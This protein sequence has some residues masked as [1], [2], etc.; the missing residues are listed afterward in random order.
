VLYHF[1]PWTLFIIALFQKNIPGKIRKNDFVFYTFLVC[2]INILV[3][4]LSPQV[5]ARFL[6]MFLPL[7]YSILFYIFF[8]YI[9]AKNWQYKTIRG[10]LAFFT[11]SLFVTFLI[12]PFLNVAEN[13]SYIYLRCF[14][15]AAAF[16]ALLWVIIKYKTIWLYFFILGIGFFRIGFNWYILEPRTKQFKEIELA[17]KHIAA[18]TRAGELYIL[19]NAGIG[20]FDG[21]S[22]HIA[23]G[24][25]KVLKYKTEIDNESFFIADKTQLKGKNYT[26]FYVFKNDNIDSLFVVKFKPAN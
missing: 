3:Y 18:I 11:F 22:Y 15:L 23:T 5:Y 8:E 13:R 25:N 19:N 17:G 1:A 9:T 16:A 4:W 20:N 14:F 26:P 6:F 2:I 24:R 12:L 7:L 21:L 10:L